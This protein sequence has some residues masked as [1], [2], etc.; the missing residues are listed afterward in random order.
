MN[1][2]YIVEGPIEQRF[3]EQARNKRLVKMGQVRVFNLMQQKIKDRSNIIAK[4]CKYIFCIIDTDC[5]CEY[6]L[7][8]FLENMKMLDIAGTVI[9]FVQNKNFE[10]EL[11]YILDQKNIAR[12]C[13]FL[14]VPHN[15]KKDLKTFLAQAVMYSF[16][17][18]EHLEKYC[19]RPYDFM[20]E[21]ENSRQV[22]K[23]FKLDGTAKRLIR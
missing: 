8:I 22:Q 10:D 3:L 4:K 13:R 6:N 20:K 15:S 18:K 16:I 5:I 23:G 14:K 9:V 1:N 7:Q 2:L 17:K 21:L 11:L 19:S 12:L